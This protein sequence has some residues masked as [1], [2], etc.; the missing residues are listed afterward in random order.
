V[1]VE[2]P[3]RAVGGSQSVDPGFETDVRHLVASRLVEDAHRAIS[4]VGDPHAPVVDGEVLGPL[5]HL[6]R[7]DHFVRRGIDLHDGAV[8]VVRDPYRV[9]ADRDPVRFGADVDGGFDRAVG[10]VDAEHLAGAVGGDPDRV[11]TDPESG[12][13]RAQLVGGG[14]LVRLGVDLDQRPVRPVARPDR[15][16]AGLDVVDLAGDLNRGQGLAAVRVDSC[17]CLRAAAHPYRVEADGHA[18]RPLRDGECRRDFVGRRVD[19]DDSVGAV[20]ADPDPV[21]T[22]AQLA[23]V[24]DGIDLGDREILGERA[25]RRRSGRRCGR[26]RLR[27]CDAGRR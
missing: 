20:R 13:A 17:D 11:G 5:A 9:V 8:A 12:G 26:R 18:A 6:E 1:E 21:E 15:V 7:P 27:G 14:D 16:G 2:D 10:R 24:L 4:A 19:A 3:D 23:R 22:L 25:C